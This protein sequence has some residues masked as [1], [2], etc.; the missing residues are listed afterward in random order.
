MKVQEA[1]DLGKRIAILVQT[2]QP[3]D[4]YAMLAPILSERT[5]FRLLRNIGEPIG[6]NPP[7]FTDLFLER[8]AADKTEGGWVI[9]ASVLRQQLDRDPEGVFARCRKYIIIGDVWYAADILGEGVPGEALVVEFEQ[10]LTLL[11]PWRE[12]ANHWVR[13]AV[14][15]SVHYWAKRSRGSPANT[16]QA[17]VLLTFLEPMFGE[18]DMSAVKGIGWGLK[19]LG[20]HYP[21][22]MADWLAQQVVSSQRRYRALMLRKA[23][24][25]LSEGQRARALGEIETP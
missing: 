4:A 21:D 3:D 9:L 10:S 17:K 13:R 18:W 25:Y 14:G 15:T 23:L 22:L 19:T 12:E 6:I 7:Q 20:R 5:P 16:K 2:G 24:T 1:R 11:V 8:I